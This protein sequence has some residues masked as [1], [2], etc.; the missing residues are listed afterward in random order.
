MTRDKETMENGLAILFWSM[1]KGKVHT[2]I[3]GI[4][5]KWN[6][7]STVDVQPAIQRKYEGKDPQN[8]PIVQ[9]VP[10]VFPGSGD[11]WLTFTI[12]EGD[13]VLLI[14]SERSLDAWKESADITDPKSGRAFSLADGIAIPGLRKIDDSVQI[15]PGLNLGTVDGTIGLNIDGD[16]ITIQ[17]GTGTWEMASDGK[18]SV[19]GTNL[20]VEK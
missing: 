13:P 19:N 15:P 16:T 20:T 12:N 14:C 4:V 17:N 18:V 7:G 3:P 1:M 5:T 8:L 2:A 11:I 10:L 9:N 6:G